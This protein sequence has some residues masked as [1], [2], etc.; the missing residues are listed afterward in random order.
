MKPLT[1]RIISTLSDM[2]YG[3]PLKSAAMRSSLTFKGLRPASELS[4]RIKRN[5][6]GPD[7]QPEVLLRRVWKLRRRNPTYRRRTSQTTAS[8]ETRPI[9][10]LRTSR[11]GLL[12]FFLSARGSVA[13]TVATIAVNP[14]D[15]T[16][17]TRDLHRPP[18]LPRIRIVPKSCTLRTLSA[19]LGQ[20]RFQPHLALCRCAWHSLECF[21]GLYVVQGPP[22]LVIWLC[23]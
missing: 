19:S 11:A 14:P 21:K 16:P 3:T 1:S 6:L 23:R 7:T 22:S 4:S 2:F 8:I 15:V 9:R 13:A 17:W 18:R 10:P 12:L 20:S 5:D